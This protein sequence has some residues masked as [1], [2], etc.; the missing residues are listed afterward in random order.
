MS[1]SGLSTVRIEE[2]SLCAN[3]PSPKPLD[4]FKP[5]SHNLVDSSRTPEILNF[6]FPNQRLFQDDAGS[7]AKQRKMSGVGNLSAAELRELNEIKDSQILSLHKELRQVKESLVNTK[8]SLEDT[9]SKLKVKEDIMSAL[10][11]KLQGVRIGSGR[12]E[13]QTCR[14]VY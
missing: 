12:F 2:V 13:E 3:S 4:F 9:S 11:K 8:K 5:S 7:S 14:S 1:I 6:S 10:D